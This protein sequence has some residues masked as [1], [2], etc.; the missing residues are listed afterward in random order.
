M[1]IIL[2]KLSEK[3]YP[4][5]RDGVSDRTLRRMYGFPTE[6]SDETAERIFRH[7]HSL[8]K[9]L[10]IQSEDKKPVGFLLDVEP[11]LPEETLSLQSGNGRTLAFAIYPAYQR[12]GYMEAALR[13]YM[14]DLLE[15]RQADWIHCGHFPWND[16]S[17]ALLA[18]LGFVNAGTHFVG[19]TAIVD[20][21][22]RRE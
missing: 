21:I 6:W 11:E 16:A 18:K 12:M 4:A 3:D 13:R 9:A 19:K 14:G 1:E 8:E 5:F 22:L 20:M 2:K 10:S 7:F 17:A 15:T